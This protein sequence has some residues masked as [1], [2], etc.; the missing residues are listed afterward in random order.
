MPSALAALSLL[1]AAVFAG[2][3][4]AQQAGVEIQNPGR[5][6]YTAAP[7][8]PEYFVDRWTIPAC[9]TAPAGIGNADDPGEKTCRVQTAATVGVFFGKSR[10]VRFSQPD[11]ATLS[12]TEAGT[13]AREVAD[14]GRARTDRRVNFN[15]V[16]DPGRIVTLW[17]GCGGQTSDGVRGSEPRGCSVPAGNAPVSVAVFTGPIPVR[18]VDFS[19]TPNGTLVAT[20]QT[21]VE[22][23]PGDRVP[24]NL[25]VTFTAIPDDGYF[26]LRW[27]E[28]CVGQGAKNFRGNPADGTPKNCLILPND[29][30][31]ETS[32]AF[33][34][35]ARPV[36]DRILASHLDAHCA[37]AGGVLSTLYQESSGGLQSS[38]G[39]VAR[40]CTFSGAPS[41][42]CHALDPDRAVDF[43]AILLVDFQ[44][45]TIVHR[46]K[47]D[48]PPR[49]D[50]AHPET[51]PDNAVRAMPNNPLAPCPGSSAPPDF[52]AAAAAGTDAARASLA[53]YLAEDP[54]AFRLSLAVANADANTP[55]QSALTA[56][57]A[58]AANL[59]N[60][61]AI[62]AVVS[63]FIAEGADV[64]LF[65]GT[66][67]ADDGHCN[68]RRWNLYDYVAMSGLVG[69]ND[70][71][72]F[73]ANTVHSDLRIALLLRLA[74][75]GLDA[76]RR[77]CRW[78]NATPQIRAAFWGLD[79]IMSVFVQ[80]PNKNLDR[81]SDSG[82]FPL[83]DVVE[84][85]DANN[86]NDARGLAVIRL[87]LENG[88][89]TELTK[90]GK[91]PL[92]RLAE[93][94]PFDD[95]AAA[96]Q[97]LRDAGMECEQN[98]NIINTDYCPPGSKIL[99]V[100]SQS[101]GGTLSAAAA[102][103]VAVSGA[104]LPAETAVT[105]TADPDPGRFVSEWT[106]A[107][108]NGVGEIATVRSDAANKTCVVSN[109]PAGILEAGVVFE[110]A[111]VSVALV[112]EVKKSQP[113]AEAVL[114]LLALGA[115]PDA[116]DGNAEA[117][118][119]VPPA[120][121]QGATIISILITAGAD[122]RA[123]NEINNND[124]RS[125]PIN[126]ARVSDNAD[127]LPALVRALRHFIAAV[128]ETEDD[129]PPGPVHDWNHSTGAY[130]QALRW[131]RRYCNFA[132][133]P[134][135][136]RE[137]AALMSERG[138]RCQGGSA[139]IAAGP[140]DVLCEPAET[141][142][143]ELPPDFNDEITVIVA[144]DFGRAKFNLSV[145][146][147][148]QLAALSADGWGV[149]LN[150]DARPHRVVVRRTAPLPAA[151]AAVFTVTANRHTPAGDGNLAREYR[152]ALTSP[153]GNFHNLAA[154]GTESARASLALMLSENPVAF[155]LSLSAR[156]PL[157]NTPLQSAL[158]AAVDFAANLQNKPALPAVVSLFIANGAAWD[159]YSGTTRGPSG[160]NNNRQWNLFQYVAKRGIHQQS[161]T[162]L[163]R[164]EPSD[165]RLS[166]LAELGK[167]DIETTRADCGAGNV[168]M[169]M[170]AAFW[171]LPRLLTVI[172]NSRNRDFNANRGR[173]AILR[174][175]VDAQRHGHWRS[176]NPEP[177]VGVLR[178]LLDNGAEVNQRDDGGNPPGSAL[179]LLVGLAGDW[180]IRARSAGDRIAELLIARGGR[181]FTR[182][183]ET[184]CPQN[185]V[186]R[187]A[188]PENGS[189]SAAS[190]GNPVTV[191][192]QITIGATITFTANPDP[193]HFVAA[194][195]GECQTS[196]AIATVQTD[197]TNKTCEI[198]NAPAGIITVG[199]VVSP[200]N[201]GDLLYAE[202]KKPVPSPAA[203]LDLL[204]RGANP[205]HRTTVTNNDGDL[206]DGNRTPAQEIVFGW[207]RI[208]N[209]N[210]GPVT[211]FSRA[212]ILRIL[213]AAGATPNPGGRD[214]PIQIGRNTDGRP[215]SAGA[216]ALPLQL[217]MLRRFIAAVARAGGEYQWTTNSANPN[218]RALG[219]AGA[220]CKADE[221]I[222]REIAALMYERGS[223]CETGP[224]D[225]PFQLCD[226]PAEEFTFAFP[227][228]YNGSVTVITARDFGNARFDLS[229]PAFEE[230]VE[231]AADGWSIS[232]TNVR[233]QQVVIQ[234][235]TPLAAGQALNLTVTATH[236]G[237]PARIY[238]VVATAPEPSFHNLAAAGTPAALAALQ[239]ILAENPDRFR[240]SLSAPNAL[241]NTPLQSALTAAVARNA[242][243][244]NKPA[245]PAVVS[246]FI[247]NGAEWNIYSGT[248]NGANPCDNNRQWNLYQYVAK[249]ET[250]RDNGRLDGRWGFVVP[251]RLSVL[252]ELGKTEIETT[253]ADCGAGNVGMHMRAARGIAELV[254]V[255]AGARN[256]DFD[257]NRGGGAILREVV[258]GRQFPGYSAS[259]VAEVL[260][261]LLDEGGANVNQRDNHGRSGLDRLVEVAGDSD[262]RNDG[263]KDALRNIFIARGGRCFTNYAGTNDAETAA[264]ICPQNTV[265][266]FS[267]SPGGVLSAAAAGN[268]VTVGTEFT[269]AATITFTANPNS[270]H[271]VSRWTGDCDGVGAKRTAH[272]DGANK[273]CILNN[274]PAGTV[275]VAAVF[276]PNNVD[277]LL[278]AE[279]NGAFPDPAV[280]VSLLA[281]EAD[282][283]YRDPNP[284]D[285]PYHGRNLLQQTALPYRKDSSNYA[286]SMRPEVVSIL[287]TAGA[288][289]NS[290]ERDFLIQIGRNSDDI[291]RPGLQL[292]I[293][294]VRHFLAAIHEHRSRN[295]SAPD[296]NWNHSAGSPVAAQDNIPPEEKLRDPGQALGWVRAY[297]RDH[298][299]H[300]DLCG[301][302]AALM[303]ERGSRCAIN[304]D[305]SPR[306]PDD[307]L[308]QVPT[309]SVARELPS[310]SDGIV[311]VITARDF[312]GARF[313][314]SVPGP[315]A[316]ATLAADGW[317]VA[318]LDVRPQ[319]VVVARNTPIAAG[320]PDAVFTVTA[321]H[322]STVAVR[323]YRISVT[324]PALRVVL[325]STSCGAATHILLPHFSGTR[326]YCVPKTG[327]VPHSAA[328]CEAFNGQV[329][330][331]NCT[332]FAGL[333]C[334]SSTCPTHFTAA[335]DCHIQNKI[336]R[337]Q[338]GN[339]V[340]GSACSANQQAVG[341]LCRPAGTLQ[342]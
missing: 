274:P 60:K 230:L 215:G 295:P 26:V 121:E 290:P 313:D 231:L 192:M 319:R 182:T 338:S 8:G 179:D 224:N 329:S 65:S 11:G 132:A 221:T 201:I 71:G 168:G 241:G 79:K 312:A 268:N 308:C 294:F 289:P 172:A 19:Q 277:E 301:E 335:R 185:T 264:G 320:D 137:L 279:V 41:R 48:S 72:D 34:E 269:T 211:D 163:R 151:A 256:R 105:F 101:D 103:T 52:H 330:G 12:A 53:L 342:E 58:A 314:L 78:G 16:P 14:G 62:P 340:C 35:G 265:V 250:V 177:V 323:E 27:S 284:D 15:A 176:L 89:D 136:C 68:G 47:A 244:Q 49:C 300:P 223:R 209:L 146:N 280:V 133:D 81:T 90:D 282:P 243:L 36:D 31:I 17:T 188:Q 126:I 51:C 196:G 178:V 128:G 332:V 29:G 227:L 251:L 270:G 118:L 76:S 70:G 145:P 18:A 315:D 28:T 82:T 43:P 328:N 54:A 276:A 302:L 202:V 216:N 167:T 173:A 131:L 253:R 218:K 106:G 175:V 212:E 254:I 310:G 113:S 205:D 148:V 114:S 210:A 283:D 181:C 187:F 262:I 193:E 30:N 110:P 85:R 107:C 111:D 138:S 246:L 333:N 242:N 144:R 9:N 116:A 153:Q 255:M 57:V 154:A 263:V 40:L 306:H 1:F 240:L 64:S 74:N 108:D 213:V 235:S 183:H 123:L 149:S 337:Q 195:T 66:T 112:A 84:G 225:E 200:A 80:A 122:P 305:R 273:T 94:E 297:C 278:I 109:A 234:R 339:V 245:L 141:L 135:S 157:G 87:L 207:H 124:R 134:A 2:D 237:T 10:P 93:T 7:A 24:V 92:D 260:R 190:D 325:G 307:V 102:G 97:I 69:N 326:G 139:G 86:F 184:F 281:R 162:E 129:A 45:R 236:N 147:P 336:A 3:A 203:V 32:V 239:N 198:Q 219:W 296:Y 55:L 318:R 291:T 159:I 125:L 164:I 73:N 20:L 217:E 220:H 100:F 13:P 288:D 266:Q 155:R 298:A 199:V 228:G 83:N 321:F 50:D 341:S 143:R 152:F 150:A 169:H 44:D 247:A 257:S 42:T 267:Q 293:R 304:L 115:D 120:S 33:E 194:W 331:A 292:Q 214:I 261:V 299:Y 75:A 166:V 303:Y 56:A 206:V 229:G 170:R 46:N 88:A 142:T 59:Q 6:T 39:D 174:E 186:V 287:I 208:P 324:A 99:L 271:F 104:E 165:L 25:T 171:G 258:S 252:A 140:A 249:H 63:L 156:N 189:L 130:G 21:G 286:A 334:G 38:P 233:P 37:N 95:N 161:N 158:T 327:T 117:L 316:L 91:T 197:A 222:C 77:D 317:E 226:I 67:N 96:A 322:Q 204:A 119:L 180:D 160:C 238:R 61:P 285:P 309:E 232:K 275:S 23:N 22:V 4:A 127:N 248:T 191:G 5:A 259:E 98:A 272:S 311:T